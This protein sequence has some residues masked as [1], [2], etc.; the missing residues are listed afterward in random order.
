MRLLKPN[1]AAHFVTEEV[2]TANFLAKEASQRGLKA[3]IT[4]T[5]A[6]AAAPGA[7]GA[8][9]PGFSKALKVWM[10]NIYK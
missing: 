1:G 4:E 5:T 6:G 2:A 7:T 3:V 9:V 8:G 10:V